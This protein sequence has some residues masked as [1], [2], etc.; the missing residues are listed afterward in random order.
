MAA[1]GEFFQ[2]KWI[3]LWRTAGGSENELAGEPGFTVV[4]RLLIT[5]NSCLF[6]Y[7][8]GMGLMIGVRL[9]D[10]AGSLLEH[11]SKN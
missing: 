3:I 7:V 10:A 9:R 5:Q 8:G 11:F 6:L 4:K 1:K 2:R